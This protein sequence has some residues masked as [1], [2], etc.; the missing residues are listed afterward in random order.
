MQIKTVADRERPNFPIKHFHDAIFD[1]KVF[2]IA[3]RIIK[4]YNGGYWQYCET[5]EPKAAFMHPG[6]GSDKAMLIN[7]FGGGETEEDSIL[8]GMVCTS[9]AMLGEIE[10]GDDRL[11]E[12]HYA[13]TEAMQ[14]YAND[15]AQTEAYFLMMD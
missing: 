15:T 1:N 9:Y 13:L 2:N 6:L 3:D 4:D 12:M 8:S 14:A 11:R 10:K 5:D 7:P